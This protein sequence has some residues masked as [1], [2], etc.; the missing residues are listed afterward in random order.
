MAVYDSGY[1]TAGW[2]E[3]GGTAIS[4]DVMAGVYALAST[5]ATGTNPAS[6]PYA[7]ASALNDITSGS[8]GSCP[9]AV[10]CTAGT[11]WD[12]PT[13]NGSPSFTAG[14]DNA[15]QQGS[16]VRSGLANRCLDDAGDATSSGAKVDIYLC[17]GTAA[18]NW[19]DLANGT[20]RINGMCLD[21]RQ[22]PG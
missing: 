4:A 20:V 1:T 12:G 10:L 3:A 5:P 2:L 16:V 22:V 13:G 18:Q 21:V 14:F 19:A 9:T 11:G 7:H 6:F 15:G 17:N 8:D